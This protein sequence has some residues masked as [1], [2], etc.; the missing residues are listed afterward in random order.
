[1]DGCPETWVG[2]MPQVVILAGGIG[3]RLRDV[4]AGR[5]KIL[6]PV[7]GRPFVEWQFDLLRRSGVRDVLLCVGHAAGQIEAHV[8]D[9][10]RFG[11]QVH[12][13]RENPAALLGTGGALVNA[14]P[15]LAARFLVLYGDS[16]LPIDYQKFSG[17]FT[18]CGLPAMM[19]VFRNEGRWDHSNVRVERGRVTLYDKHALP[20]E[21]D[22]IDYGLIGMTRRVIEEHTK[23]TMPLDLATV[24]G[25]LVR[26][27]DVA[28][29]VAPC[30]FYEIG[31]PEGLAELSRH[32]AETH[33]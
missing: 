29:W 21:A 2:G 32:L 3:S 23:D 30:R 12:F 4:S 1:M 6:V 24:L 26:R 33:S 14:L 25:N 31:R 16:Y 9:G 8:G 17:A 19:S 18:A 7:A 27:G 5:P 15:M 13:S 28:A 11:I 22:C 20:G 10:T